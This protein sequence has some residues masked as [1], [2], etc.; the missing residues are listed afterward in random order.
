ME[1][2][3]DA[4]P[5]RD[6]CESTGTKGPRFEFLLVRSEVPACA[7]RGVESSRDHLASSPVCWQ[8]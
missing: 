7:V 8:A 1:G 3:E 2:L 6:E 4:L 5:A